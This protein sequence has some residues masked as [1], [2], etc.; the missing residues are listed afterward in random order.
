M[1]PFTAVAPPPRLRLSDVVYEQLEKMIVDGVLAPGAAL[2]SERDL[3][4]QLQVSRPP[5][6]EALHKLE[7][8]GLIS[9]RNGGGYAVANA[10]TPLIADPLAQLL[11][12]HP[13]AASD[14]FELRHGLESVSVQLAAERAEAGDLAKLE[15][16]TEELEQAYR[17]WDEPEQAALLPAL[18]ARFHLLIAEATHNVALVHVMHALSNLMQNAVQQ[19]YQQ[20]SAQGA[21][22]AA[23]I[24]QHRRILAAIQAHDPAAGRQA[25]E[26]HLEYIQ[27]NWG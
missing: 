16:I 2:P 5:L 8:R 7:T 3:A 10:S 21:D 23:L 22:I 18:D 12:R 19:N 17:R 24:A 14:I 9:Q 13:K 11:A 6:R 20:L 4:E 25:V 27:Q 1:P 15:Q 26:E